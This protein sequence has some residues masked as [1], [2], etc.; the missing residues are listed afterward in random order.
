MSD[1]INLNTKTNLERLKLQLNN[2]EYYTD[3]EFSLFLE[4]NE[5]YPN[6]VYV[7]S[8]MEIKLLET[9]VTVLE[10]L[11]NDID[12]M[13]KIDTTELGLSTEEAYK[14]LE[15]RIKSLNEKILNLKEEQ[16]TQ[17]YSNVRPLFFTNIITK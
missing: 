12:L 11:S 13:R 8:T 6:D 9:V 10:T 14:Y 1:M 15:K 2:K 17:E 16:E 7:K 4:E 5:L 3:D